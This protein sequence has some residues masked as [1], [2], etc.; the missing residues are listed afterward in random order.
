MAGIGKLYKMGIYLIRQVAL[1][2]LRRGALSRLSGFAAKAPR[3]ARRIG[4]ASQKIQAKAQ[5][6]H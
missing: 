4:K 6:G 5:H 2:T 1:K 3:T